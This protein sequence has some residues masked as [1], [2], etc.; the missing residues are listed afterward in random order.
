MAII[1]PLVFGQRVRHYRKAAKMTLD[2]LGVKVSKPAPFLS[3]LENGKKEPK[4]GLINDLSIALGV[5]VSDLLSVTAPSRRAEMEVAIERAQRDQAYRDLGLP[6]L[7]ASA[8]LPDAALEHIVRLYEELRGRDAAAPFTRDEARAAN[9]QLRA[10]M[11]ERGNYFGEIESIAADAVRTIGY[12]G[13]GAMSKG[14]LNALAKHFG[15][16]V[17]RTSDLP[18]SVR[19]VTDMRNG[20]IFVHGRDS[21][22]SKLLRS[23]I[24]QTL[25]HFALG[26]PDAKD[27]AEFLR[28]RVE[29]NYFAG[30]VLLPESAAVPYLREAKAERNLSIEDFKDRFF[31]SYEMAGHRFTNL[32]TEHLDLRTHFVRSDEQGI[33]W[34]AYANN[35]VPFP[36]N[37]AGAIEGQRLCREWGTRQAF[38]SEA[39]YTIHYQYTDTSAGTFWCATF[40]ETKSEPAS[41]ITV[42]ARFEDAKWFRGWNTDRRSASQ[43]PDGDCCRTVSDA[44]AERWNGNSWPSVRPNS[45][46]LAA[47]PVETVP[48]VDMVEIYEFLTRQDDAAFQ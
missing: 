41:A 30:A 7:K 19:S 12:E 40:V 38:T 29:A 44:M 35:G 15:F 34:K 6:Y 45:H 21:F 43:C 14:D 18:A 2:A 4:L 11:T 25:G 16:K 27:F 9:A 46:V 36:K 28:Q 32:A 22:D 47:M 8:R 13:Q 33:I 1:D 10:E 23:V 31:A 26:H 5:D 39:K 3:L 42:G 20:R 17:I 24:L 37:S 48:G